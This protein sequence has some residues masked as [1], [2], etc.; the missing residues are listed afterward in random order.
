MDQA[1]E[2]LKIYLNKNKEE[3]ITINQEGIQTC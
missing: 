2:K 1:L 3:C